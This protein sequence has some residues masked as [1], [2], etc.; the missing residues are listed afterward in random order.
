[1]PFANGTLSL[2]LSLVVRAL[3]LLAVLHPLHELQLVLETDT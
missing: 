3:Q 2:S 1:M